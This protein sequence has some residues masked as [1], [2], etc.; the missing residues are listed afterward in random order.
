MQDIIKHKIDNI[1]IQQRRASG[2]VH[3][4]PIMSHFGTEAREYFSSKRG[5]E[6]IRGL[7]E[8]EN[9]ASGLN[10]SWERGIPRSRNHGT[11]LVYKVK[12]FKE[13]QGTW[14]HHV[15]AHDMTMWAAPPKLQALWGSELSKLIDN[16]KRRNKLTGLQPMGLMNQRGLPRGHTCLLIE[17]YKGL[18]MYLEQEQILIN[19]DLRPELSIAPA[20]YE[21][22]KEE[23]ID[24][25]RLPKFTFYFT[26]PQITPKLVKCFHNRHVW[27]YR[28]VEEEWMISKAEKYFKERHPEYLPAIRNRIRAIRGLPPVKE[29]EEIT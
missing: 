15:L 7:C 22:M 24:T 28:E 17:M 19:E 26:R 12:S 9:K 27:I 6:F 8:I 2:Y 18:F 25:N 4:T 20:F 13:K 29:K 16:S 1:I 11:Y 5:E 14:V 3:I 21:R 10:Y 23:G